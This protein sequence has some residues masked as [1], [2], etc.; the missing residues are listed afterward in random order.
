MML[1]EFCALVRCGVIIAAESEDIAR[2]E[3]E[4]YTRAWFETGDFLEV[5]DVELTDVRKPKTDDFDDEAHVSIAP[6][7]TEKGGK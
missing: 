7:N 3:I 1:Y 6:T 2:K 5:L 4:T